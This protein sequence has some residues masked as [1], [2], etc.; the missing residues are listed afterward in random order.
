[1]ETTKPIARYVLPVMAV[2]IS[3]ASFVLPLDVVALLVVATVIW[4]A[5]VVG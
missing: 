1:M 5:R 4:R 3:A 2:V